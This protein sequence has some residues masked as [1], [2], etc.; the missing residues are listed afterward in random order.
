MR[1]SCPS[2]SRTAYTYYAPQKSRV[3]PNARCREGLVLH[4]VGYEDGGKLR[5]VLHR[6]SLVEMAV[7]YGDPR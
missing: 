2:S 4:C 7:P 3:T 1:R 5:P 6:A